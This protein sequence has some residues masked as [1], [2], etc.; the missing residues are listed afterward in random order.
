MTLLFAVPILTSIVVS[1]CVDKTPKW[2]KKMLNVFPD[3]LAGKCEKNGTRVQ[4]EFCCGT[5]NV[6]EVM[7]YHRKR[8]WVNGDKSWAKNL[9]LKILRQFSILTI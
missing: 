7:E 8:R 5:C 6:L 4:D 1:E 9:T 2:C 3:T